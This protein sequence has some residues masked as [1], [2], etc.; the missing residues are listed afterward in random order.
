MRHFAFAGLLSAGLWVSGCSVAVP[1]EAPALSEAPH[2]ARE[3]AGEGAEGDTGRTEAD[4]ALDKQAD[5]KRKKGYADTDMP[6]T[7]A[8]PPPPVAPTE[9]Q[10][11]VMVLDKG[12]RAIELTLGY[13]GQVVT[14]QVA[15]TY[16]SAGE[17][18]AAFVRILQA[19]QDEG[20]RKR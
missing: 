7:E 10:S 6:A 11:V 14:T 4:A 2:L 19:L 3:A 13:D 12:G 16:D 20:Y 18:A 8:A 5:S 1:M 9:P 15:E 17:A